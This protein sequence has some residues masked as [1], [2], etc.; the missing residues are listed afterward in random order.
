MRPNS[1]SQTILPFPHSFCKYFEFTPLQY[2][3]CNQRSLSLGSVDL[4][5]LTSF[6]RSLG[7][8]VPNL[9]SEPWWFRKR[10]QEKGEKE[11]VE[12]KR[13][14]KVST[15]VS[16]GSTFQ[17]HVLGECKRSEGVYPISPT[18]NKDS[19]GP[20]RVGKVWGEVRVG[21]VFRRGRRVPSVSGI[22]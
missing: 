3:L 6:T 1:S 8:G 22:W 16:R 4:R 14:K 10:E 21:P 9:T 2:D 12:T 5:I 18:T 11:R 17:F 15:A 7:P 19:V 20:P 13:N